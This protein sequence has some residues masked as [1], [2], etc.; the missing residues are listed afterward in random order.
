MRGQLSVDVVGADAGAYLDAALAGRLSA[1]AIGKAKYSRYADE[2]IAGARELG[3]CAVGVVNSNHCGTLAFFLE[4]I[5][6][7]GMPAPGA[8]TGPAVMAYFGGRSRAVGT[9]PLGYAIPRPDGPPIIL[10]MATSNAARGKI[11]SMAR[12]G[13]GTVPPPLRAIEMILPRA[14]LLVAMS[15]MMGGPSG[16]GMAYPRGLVPTARLRPPK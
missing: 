13:G 1:L 9:N 11:I 5:A 6:N 7:A 3:I 15:R 12:S 16:R 8:P 4:K 10:D 14:A 2:A